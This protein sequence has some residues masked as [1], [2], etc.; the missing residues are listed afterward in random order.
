[1]CLKNYFCNLHAPI[2]GIFCFHSVDITRYATLVQAKF[3]TNCN[4]HLSESIFQIHSRV[5]IFT[6]TILKSFNMFI[7]SGMLSNLWGGTTSRCTYSLSD[8]SKKIKTK[9][10]DKLEFCDFALWNSDCNLASSFSSKVVLSGRMERLAQRNKIKLIIILR[11]D[12]LSN[13]AT[14][15]FAAASVIYPPHQQDTS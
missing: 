13:P 10:Y 14:D 15:L 1:M 6:V 12:F 2:C 9:D 7:T 3:S 4:A 11:F 8:Y 5:S